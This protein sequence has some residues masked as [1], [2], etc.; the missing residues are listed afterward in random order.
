[1]LKYISSSNILL[2]IRMGPVA[3]YVRR[4][5]YIIIGVGT[6]ASVIIFLV[7]RWKLKQQIDQLSRELSTLRVR[8]DEI[9]GE[10]QEIRETFSKS[11]ASV[12]NSVDRL[13]RDNLLEELES[14]DEDIFEEAEEG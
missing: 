5:T 11:N 1:M 4:N 12:C 6:T 14:S 3:D 10:I 13:T 2:V 9:S 7:H 8:F